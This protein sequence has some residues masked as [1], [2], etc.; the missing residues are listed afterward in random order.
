LVRGGPWRKKKKRG[1]RGAYP[2]Q[3]KKKEKKGDI[4]H[5]KS[6][7]AK[8]QGGNQTRSKKKTVKNERPK[9]L[10]PKNW[11]EGGCPRPRGEKKSKKKNRVGSRKRKREG[12]FS[13]EVQKEGNETPEKKKKANTLSKTKENLVHRSSRLMT[14]R[15]VEN[16]K[17][18]WG[19]G[20]FGKE[21]RAI[22]KKKELGEGGWCAPEWERTKFKKDTTA[23]LRG[24]GIQSLKIKK[25]K[26]KKSGRTKRFSKQGKKT[27]DKIQPKCPGGKAMPRALVHRQ[28]GGVGTTSGYKDAWEREPRNAQEGEKGTRWV[29]RAEDAGTQ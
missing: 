7:L 26:K 9:L 14:A 2:K 5:S 24:G 19:E 23:S 22:G 29:A 3:K 8:L 20:K 28:E 25:R 6:L 10:V 1:G 18:N 15:G 12:Q 13:S 11:Q 27:P 4:P 17:P 16:G 21:L